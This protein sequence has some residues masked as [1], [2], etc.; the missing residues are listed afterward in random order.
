MAGGDQL[1][2]WDVAGDAVDGAV[3]AVV[4]CVDVAAGQAASG[5]DDVFGGKREVVDGAQNAAVSGLGHGHLLGI[6]IA[7]RIHG[8]AF[9]VQRGLDRR[10]DRRADRAQAPRR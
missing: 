1:D 8:Q 9:G 10:D 3:Q 4:Q 6:K 2:R 7:Q 5:G